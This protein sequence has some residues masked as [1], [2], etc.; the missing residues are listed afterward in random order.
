MGFYRIVRVNGRVYELT[1]NNY[2]GSGDEGLSFR[3]EDKVI[4][5][6]NFFCMKYRLG[7][8]SVDIMREIPTNRILMPQDKVFDVDG[9]FC[10]YTT[11]SIEF[12]GFDY[13]SF[14]IKNYLNELLEYEKEMELLTSNNIITADLSISN[15]IPSNNIL[16]SIDP[17][18]YHFNEID[19]SYA[20][21]QNDI[22][23]K[24]LFIQFLC[25]GLNNEFKEKYLYEILDDG[26]RLYDNIIKNVEAENETIT[27]YRIKLLNRR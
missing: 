14:T 21:K 15:M 11:K 1:D 17:G 25:Y 19:N 10:G 24:N 7:P 6:Y 16:Y 13:D 26:N 8:G 12:K 3:V 27:S 18:S 22:E 9:N 4:K 20:K 2:I 23:L 5:L